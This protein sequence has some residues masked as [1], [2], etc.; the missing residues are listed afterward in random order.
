MDRLHE[1]RHSRHERLQAAVVER[2][3]FNGG[4]VIVPALPL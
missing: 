3:L 4:T 2:T 1:N